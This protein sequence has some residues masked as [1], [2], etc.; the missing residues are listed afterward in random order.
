VNALFFSF[1]FFRKKIFR[2][3]MNLLMMK[4][5]FPKVFSKFSLKIAKEFHP[6]NVK[7]LV[8]T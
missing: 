4:I 8:R 3:M 5:H 1:K 6:K 7:T 2:K